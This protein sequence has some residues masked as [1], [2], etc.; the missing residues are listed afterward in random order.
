MNPEENTVATSETQTPEVTQ[1]K[2]FHRL[3]CVTPFSKY[4]AIVLF[5]I[6][7]FL[8]G[9]IGYTQA[10]EKV[11]EVERVVE[12]EQVEDKEFNNVVNGNTQ[13][14]DSAAIISDD[15]TIDK[16]GRYAP[17]GKHVTSAELYEL[18]SLPFITAFS[19]EY[20]LHGLGAEGSK[21]VYKYNQTIHSYEE[22]PIDFLNI[23][24][25]DYGPRLWLLLR[26]WSS[27]LRYLLFERSGDIYYVDTEEPYLGFVK[28]DGYAGAPVVSPDRSKI[29]LVKNFDSKNGYLSASD[30]QDDLYIF[31][32]N[33]LAT[34]KIYSHDGAVKTFLAISGYDGSYYVDG[35]WLTNSQIKLSILPKD[36]F[37]ERG[38]PQ[39]HD[40]DDRKN[41]DSISEYTIVK[42]E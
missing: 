1:L 31:D 30:V 17:D 7:P 9:Y 41:Y 12:I 23:F 6:L 24:N 38:A 32:L 14:V 28:I 15:K 36:L 3:Y 39:Y 4:F 2:R 21:S 16:E 29:L 34:T 20:V 11:V 13:T 42:I 5:V 19:E 18:T 26:G 25:P 35:E 27:D 40:L 37:K 10:P 22:I 33:E 8:G